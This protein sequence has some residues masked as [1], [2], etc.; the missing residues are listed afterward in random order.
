MY[1]PLDQKDLPP[2]PKF[3]KLLGP[4][5][6][7]LGLGLGS[8]EI[9]LWPY[10]TS[11]HGLGLV[12]AILIGIT[13][14]F[15]INM[16]VERYALINGESVF[17][18]FAR[19]LKILPFWF[20]VSTFLGFGWPGIGLAG[21]TLLSNVVP[22]SAPLICLFIF[23]GIGLLLSLGKVLYKTVETLQK[24]LILIGTPSIVL[25]TL[26][27]ARSDHLLD[28]GRGLVGIG[29]DYNFLPVGISLATFLSALVYSGAG[30]NLN[31]TQG[32]Y[33]KDKGY[34]MGYYA[35]SIKNLFTSDQSIKLT[36]TTFPITAPNL[37]RFNRWWRLINLEHFLIFWLLGTVTM[38]SLSFLAYITTYHLPGNLEG[39]SFVIREAGFIAERT[40]PFIGTLFLGLTGLMLTATQLTVL[41]ST[42]RII[43]ENI[44]L[45]R[46]NS[47]VHLTKT[48]YLTLWLQ[49]LFGMIIIAAGFHQPRDLITLGAI[50]NA[51]T[52]FVYILLLVYIN[53]SKLALP[54]RPHPIRSILLILSSL[55]F[56]SLFILTVFKI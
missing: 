56:L 45:T 49:I 18:G 41:D 42:S 25:L 20:I 23:I 5:F 48:Y 14:Q 40:V 11:N 55:L 21:S 27:L 7:V 35:K 1:L 38:V 33:V 10:L 4:S 50:I 17:V 36:G 51:F 24:I 28:L 26:F 6:I 8:G 19:W 47:A 9:I 2:P 3:K 31:L 34:G 37:S 46:G 30:G 22:F 16:E 32:N 39:I 15:F 44:L 29:P 53:N 52:M 54:L 13:I 43:S 12:W